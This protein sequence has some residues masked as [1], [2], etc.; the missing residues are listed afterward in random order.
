[1]KEESTKLSQRQ[2][3]KKTS[4]DKMQ[5]ENRKER[6]SQLNFHKAISAA[7]LSLSSVFFGAH[8]HLVYMPLDPC[9][10]F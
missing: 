10:E 2:P 8:R 6:S 9:M 5:K 4:H 1:M 7:I 3:L